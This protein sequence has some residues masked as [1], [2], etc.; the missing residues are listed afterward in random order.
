[1][2]VNSGMDNKFKV[3]GIAFTLYGVLAVLA[4]ISKYM[5]GVNQLSNIQTLPTIVV[6][7]G[8]LFSVVHLLALLCGV[9][10]LKKNEAVHKIALPISI[11]ILFIIPFGTITGVIYLM[12]RYKN[13]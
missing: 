10:L 4:F 7:M 2:E 3:S 12:E 1:V 13:T 5:F 11:V 9:Y 8:S 6:F